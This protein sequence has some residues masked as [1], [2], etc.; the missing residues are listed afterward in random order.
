MRVRVYGAGHIHACTLAVRSPGIQL[1]ASETDRQ[2]VKS[3]LLTF[4]R[5]API[6]EMD[7]KIFGLIKK[8]GGTAPTPLHWCITVYHHTNFHI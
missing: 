8:W 1:F 7:G 5:A 2:S 4:E 3:L 6:A